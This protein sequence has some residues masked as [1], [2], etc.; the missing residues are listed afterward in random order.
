MAS[1]SWQASRSWKS[2]AFNCATSGLMFASFRKHTSRRCWLMYTLFSTGRQ[3]PEY[4]SCQPYYKPSLRSSVPVP[5]EH[6]P[7]R[8]NSG[9]SKG[10]NPKD[11]A[12]DCPSRSPANRYRSSSA[13]RPAFPSASVNASFCRVLSASSQISQPKLSSSPIR[14]IS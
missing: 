6:A 7:Y 14:S 5:V 4:P 9:I 8:P 11:V 2:S 10:C 13:F 12:M 1:A 3:E